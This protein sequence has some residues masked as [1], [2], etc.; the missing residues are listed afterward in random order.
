MGA[1]TCGISIHLSY[2]VGPP[3]NIQVETEVEEMLVV[4]CGDVRRYQCRR[5]EHSFVFVDLGFRYALRK[6]DSCQGSVD[7]KRTVLMEDVADRVVVVAYSRDEE[8]HEF[9]SP[10]RFI[11]VRRGV[12]VP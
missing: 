6:H 1:R 9:P 12:I 4:R 3:V 5:W 10:P 2:G 8:G 11:L 7:F